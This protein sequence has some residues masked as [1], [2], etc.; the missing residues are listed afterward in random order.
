MVRGFLKSVADYLLEHVDSKDWKDLNVVFPSHRACVF[1]RQTLRESIGERTIF[2]PNIVTMD[3]LI[4]EKAMRLEKPLRKADNLA[5]AFELYI[6]YKEIM[7]DTG[8][9]EMEFERF[10]S[11]SA[12]FLGDFDDIDKYVVDARQLLT[13][14][15]E[16]EKLGD[17]LEHLTDEQKR[18]IEAFWGVVFS[19]IRIER[20]G[21]NGQVE[22]EEKN[23]H[24]R[25]CETYDKL[26]ELYERFNERLSREG[27]AYSGKIYRTVAE[28]I[29]KLDNNPK[30][31]YA[32]VG[33]NA[34]TKSEELILNY[35]Q[36]KEGRTMF[37]WDYTDNMLE[38]L[39]KD[40]N[41]DD[42]SSQIGPGRFIRQYC[43]S[44][45]G[46]LTLRGKYPAPK[47]YILPQPDKDERQI[48]IKSYAYP[49]GQMAHI[50][51][52]LKETLTSG[53]HEGE[54]DIENTKTAIVLTDENMLISTISALPS[55]EEM[56]GREGGL[57]VNVTMGYPMKFSQA[58]GLMDLLVRLHSGARKMNGETAFYHKQVIQILQHPYIVGLC[59]EKS[60]GGKDSKGVEVTETLAARMIRENII[61]VTEEMAREYGG[62]E[63][64]IF[65]QVEARE[66]AKYVAEIFEEILTTEKRKIAE[67]EI[68]A[69]ED[70][71][72]AITQESIGKAIKT[73]RRFDGLIEKYVEGGDGQVA[74]SDPRMVMSMLGCMM[75]GQTVDFKGEPLNGL[76]IMGILETRAL[77]FDN[78]VILDLNE[79]VF[80][81]KNSSM[82]FFPYVIRKAYG[83]PTQE[84]QDS[85]FSY[86]FFRLINRAKRVDLLYSA[87]T[88]ADRQGASRYIHQ[89]K[90][91]YQMPYV[92]KIAV[93]QHTKQEMS[94]LRITKTEAIKEELKKRFTCK[95]Y[96]SPS[97]ISNY[98]KCPILFYLQN[99]LSIDEADEVVEEADSRLMGRIFHGAMETLYGE[100][101][102][103]VVDEAARKAMLEDGGKIESVIMRQFDIE[104]FK[105]IRMNAEGEMVPV[106][107]Y[108]P[109]KKSELEGR[110]IL[111]YEVIYDFVKKMLE[112]DHDVVIKGLEKMVDG[113]IETSDGMKVKIGG[114]ID[115]LHEEEGSTCVIDYKTGK[116]GDMK[117][118]AETLD[119]VVDT[120]FDIK[121]QDKYK[122][123][124]QTLI[125]AK[126]LHDKEPGKKY[127]VGVIYMLDL[128]RNSGKLDY[129]A[130]YGGKTESYGL[131]YGEID[132]AFTERLRAL[133]DEIMGGEEFVGQREHCAPVFG[134]P[135]RFNMLC[136]KCVERDV[137]SE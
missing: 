36:K 32:F 51:Q 63:E 103:G 67:T 12:M 27:M 61:Y 82:T 122:A 107:G 5:L 4:A 99:V 78:L 109:T 46:N 111:T 87:N 52:F 114:I 69:S 127:N 129:L 72:S 86:Y 123:I 18:V 30:T 132:K 23:Y 112:N 19:K 47:D 136:N 91:E 97:A 1:F 100:V 49:Q 93:H 66:V 126:I 88:D 90:F 35:L 15:A 104:M 13:H 17:N 8:M 135:C 25:Y 64:K 133:V 50:G 121:K 28:Q 116:V 3:D 105:K 80:P 108:R 45:R 22:I 40:D 62:I 42:P 95:R 77:D 16:Y 81:K 58:Y 53:I 37:F 55:E 65:K 44:Q 29:D 83:L 9:A 56:S 11:W 26:L 70:A 38:N 119:K 33:F 24:E 6:A 60:T 43:C 20:M 14:V 7:A 115:R 92:E 98:L 85:I 106:E 110:N 41:A 54:V 89:I 118:A 34:L 84:Y 134:Q 74:V 39:T 75:Q 21:A 125:Y 131:E 101:K 96:L 68:V 73:A 2:G 120:V 94:E 137:E 130:K 124:L 113:E 128:L 59:N 76:Q 102:N 57:K 10:Y 117:V 48:T 79:G 31:K 71:D